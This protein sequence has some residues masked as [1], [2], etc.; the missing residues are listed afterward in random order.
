MQIDLINELERSLGALRGVRRVSVTADADRVTAVRVLVVPERAKDVVRQE[1]AALAAEVLGAPL[2]PEVLQVYSAVP[3]VG[4]TEHVRRRKLSRISTDRS[5]D[6]FSVRVTL[7]LGGDVLIGEEIGPPG[8]ELERRAVVMAT[9]AGLRELLE[10]EVKLEDVSTLHRGE[11]R[12]V[13]VSLNTGD[14]AVLGVASVRLDDHDAIVRAT[15]QA[16]NR[17]LE[18]RPVPTP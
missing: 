17:L 11:E 10:S 8:A 12:L 1:I 3:P 18:T 4:G 2:E 14:T 16:L 9:L 13:A 6:G 15:L 5:D 7:E